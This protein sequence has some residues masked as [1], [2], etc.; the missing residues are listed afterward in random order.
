MRV[1][2]LTRNHVRYGATAVC[3]GCT[4]TRQF[5]K[6]GTSEHVNKDSVAA[7][8]FGEGK[9]STKQAV[10]QKA[11]K[12][13][14]KAGTGVIGSLVSGS[15]WKTYAEKAPTVT[16]PPKSDDLGKT[17]SDSSGANIVSSILS[18]KL[19]KASATDDLSKSEPKVLSNEK[20]AVASDKWF[21]DMEY[22]ISKIPTQL[23]DNRMKESLQDFAKLGEGV[24]RKVGR[25]PEHPL[26]L[27][28]ALL[29]LYAKETHRDSSFLEA[30][31]NKAELAELSDEF[32]AEIVHYF[33]FAEEVYEADVTVV[34]QDIV[35]NQLEENEALH[36]PRHIVFLD[37]LTKSIVVAIRGTSS[38]HDVI[39]DL[40]I[41]AAPF[42]D[43]S[44]QVYAHKG[45]AESA[46]A[47]LPSITTT[48]NKIRNERRYANYNVVTT[49]H[50]LGAGSAALL[51]ILLST[52][53]KIAVE[54]F[55]F[56]PPPIISKPDVH[57]SRFPFEFMNSNASC[58]IHSFV[59]DRDFISRCSHKELLNMLSALT[60][61][62]AL[63]WSD[64]ERSSVVFRNKLSDE[65]KQQIRS[66][67]EHERRP[68]VDG[69]DVALYVPGDIMLLRPVVSTEVISA[70]PLPPAPSTETAV[71][72]ASDASGYGD[73]GNSDN[74]GAYSLG[75]AWQRVM[76]TVS[77]QGS[78]VMAS[79]VTD[80]TPSVTE[81]SEGQ[82]ANPVGAK[83]TKNDTEKESE[84]QKEKLRL[85]RL[86]YEVFAVHCS[87]ACCIM[88]IPWSPT[89][90]SLRTDVHCC[91]C[92]S[93]Q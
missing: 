55:A 89:T 35:L 84:R 88:V 23:L 51:A 21:T 25:K 66:V 82:V 2:R 27:N 57:E 75:G 81:I 28:I 63:P 79:S 17:P 48:I 76:E 54:C 47:M 26:F 46:Q 80:T 19:W 92:S 91:A 6:T 33:Q 1:M 61:I 15:L 30:S 18:G 39:T 72:G 7:S 4:T 45:I 52:E 59:H 77:A 37:H 68:I 90:L 53:S 86:Q 11:L 69:N 44:R 49:G 87:M 38:L 13:E 31:Q 50:S 40:Y 85:E 3:A 83:T 36:I 34:R 32:A 14:A 78:G 62:D 22:Y 20:T 65:E 8:E 70:Q 10:P 29:R 93:S 64:Y 67:L 24:Y 43:T 74:G 16:E 71:S 41:E 56:A 73:T 9:G 12:E 42:L 58:T 60:A 5:W